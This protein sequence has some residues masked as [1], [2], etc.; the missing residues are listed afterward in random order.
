MKTRSCA[1]EPSIRQLLD[2]I[3]AFVFLTDD[4]LAIL[5]YNSAAGNLAGGRRRRIL[6]HRGGEVL[7]CV[8]A[9]DVPEGCGRGRFCKNCLLRRAVN[10]AVAGT[11][12]VR[13]RVRMQLEAP[14]KKVR[15]LVRPG[16]GHAAGRAGEK[17]AGVADPGRRGR[18]DA[19]AEPPADLPPLQARPGGAWTVERRGG[20][21][22]RGFGPPAQQQLLSGMLG[23]S[24][25][26]G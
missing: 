3:P 25:R 20:L 7:H 4:D 1:G 8:H 23:R 12:S 15:E 14:G 6:R 19:A 11:R 26:I 13:R 22:A 10:Q 5:E 18:V 2:A 9:H 17:Q 24:G 16:F 21:F